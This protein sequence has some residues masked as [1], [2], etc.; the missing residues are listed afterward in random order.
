M[1]ARTAVPQMLDGLVEL[2]RV[3]RWS[4]PVE[5]LVG[6][7]GTVAELGRDGSLRM[8]FGRGRRVRLANGE[9]WR[10]K[11]SASGRHIVPIITSPAGTIAISGPLPAKRSYGINGKD[12]GYFLIPLGHSG[13]R[14]ARL[15]A[16][17]RHETEI[18][19]IDDRHRTIESTEP[20]PVA[21]AVM[22]FTLLV[23]GIP[24]EASLMPERD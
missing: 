17:R 6:A 5:A 9:E 23:H 19:I 20:I 10:I 4:F 8:I 22:A 18:A 13:V 14:R 24:G 12:W 11:S 7:D 16:V 3:G 2:L 21:V 15:W 1:D